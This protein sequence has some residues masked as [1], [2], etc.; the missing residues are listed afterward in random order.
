V[1]LLGASLEEL[2]QLLSR[3]GGPVA[4]NVVAFAPAL[5]P[6]RWRDAAE[7]RVAEALPG[8]PVRVDPGGGEARRF[9]AT[10]SGYVVIFDAEGRRLFS[11]GI[12]GGRSMVGDNTGFDRALNALRQSRHA[13]PATSPVYG[14][15]ILP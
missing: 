6:E 15:P 14:C 4:T 12:T 1:S 7:S 3:Y 10:T 9:G 11:G 2:A 5:N 8:V 13:S